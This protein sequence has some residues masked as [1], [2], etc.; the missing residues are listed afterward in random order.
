MNAIIIKDEPQTP[1]GKVF[2]L[3]DNA[4]AHSVEAIKQVSDN[5][6]GLA[7]ITC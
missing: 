7:W 5:A 2:I 3:E 1:T 6:N 4:Y